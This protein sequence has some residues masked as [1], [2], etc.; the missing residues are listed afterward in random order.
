VGCCATVD[1]DDV[2]TFYTT[3]PNKTERI[4]VWTE[5][6]RVGKYEV[7][8]CVM[9]AGIRTVAVYMDTALPT[10]SISK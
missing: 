3:R 9:M 1:D 5:E 6:M 4:L 2:D 8:W 7:L 10:V